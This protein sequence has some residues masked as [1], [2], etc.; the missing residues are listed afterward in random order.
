MR[1]YTFD[2]ICESQNFNHCAEFVA[3][4]DYD[5][6][7]EKLRVATEALEEIANDKSPPWDK[8]DFQKVARSTLFKIGER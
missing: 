6:L 2:E 3:S 4:G 1:K 7:E 8:T 5:A